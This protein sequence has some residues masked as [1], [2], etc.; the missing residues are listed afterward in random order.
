MVAFYFQVFTDYWTVAGQLFLFQK[1]N[2]YISTKQ[3]PYSSFPVSHRIK[4]HSSRSKKHFLDMRQFIFSSLEVILPSFKNLAA[5]IIEQF[6][7]RLP[8]WPRTEKTLI[9]SELVM[10]FYR[11]IQNWKVDWF[12]DQVE[13]RDWLLKTVE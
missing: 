3:T 7:S 10:E 13:S 6:L 9:I 1:F 4:S 2:F 5:N 12:R 8:N 11:T